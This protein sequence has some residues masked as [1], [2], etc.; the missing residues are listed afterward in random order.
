MSTKILQFG[1]ALCG[2]LLI[3]LLGFIGTTT[4]EEIGL[5]GGV[6]VNG[7]TIDPSRPSINA[8]II[9]THFPN[10]LAYKGHDSVPPFAQAAATFVK[11]YYL[12]MSYGKHTVNAQVIQ[13][14]APNNGQA[15]NASDII[16]YYQIR[17]LKLN[18]E[19]LDA[20]WNENNNV[21]N[22]IDF[23]FMCY[24][25]NVFTGG[26][27]Y[28]GLV[29]NSTHYSGAGVLI[30]YGWEGEG[31]QEKLLKWHFAHEYGHRIALPGRHTFEDQT[32]NVPGP[33]DIMY[34]NYGGGIPP[35]AAFHLNYLGWLENSW[36]RDIN[37]TV[38]GNQP[39]QIRAC[40]EVSFSEYS[41]L[42][43]KSPPKGVRCGAPGVAI[44]RRA[45][46]R[47]GRGE[48]R[49]LEVFN[50]FFK[51]FEKGTFTLSCMLKSK[52]GERFNNCENWR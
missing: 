21:F 12:S 24:E 31:E 23:I 22:G 8:L 13:R 35:M 49:D 4:A 29:H 17:H 34:P 47:S 38:D 40:P 25:G 2:F 51:I 11:D 39:N 7:N 3:V 1:S 26:T 45:W 52:A 28:G 42:K 33:Y 16:V 36:I 14:P 10:D 6:E 9:F 43:G 18:T 5:C 41:P 32:D 46:A 19:I 30:E 37:P 20:A 27:A 48:R 15:F 44:E 50:D